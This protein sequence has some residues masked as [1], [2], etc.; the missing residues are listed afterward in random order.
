MPEIVRS[1]QYAGKSGPL[2]SA[3]CL[4]PTAYFREAIAEEAGPEVLVGGDSALDREFAV[5]AEACR[6]AVAAASL[7]VVG[8]LD[9][10]L[11]QDGRVAGR[12]E[13]A[14]LAG[15][16]EVL[17]PLDGRAHHGASCRHGL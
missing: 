11:A 1:T 7:G 9:Q 15:D 8:P 2:P 10:G 4:L 3:Y 16:N 5:D 6:L 17:G 13:P 12:D 14:G